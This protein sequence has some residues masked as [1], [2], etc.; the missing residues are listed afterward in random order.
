MSI[1][2]NKPVICPV[3][4]SR[5]LELAT[6]YALIDQARRG[7]GQVVLISGE[8]GIGKSRLAAEVKTQA[9][10]QALR[11][12]GYGRMIRSLIARVAQAVEQ[13]EQSSHA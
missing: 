9:N 3:L 7:L 5:K 6:L 4:I 8:A 13:D 11:E 12:D 2:F 1:V 10:E